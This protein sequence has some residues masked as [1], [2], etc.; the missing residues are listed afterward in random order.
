MNRIW[1]E[2]LGQGFYTPVDDMGPERVAMFEE[3]LDLLAEGFV[4]SQYDVKWVYRTIANTQAYQRKIQAVDGSE[5]VPPFA[6]AAPTRLSSDQIYQSLGQVLG[7]PSGL[8]GGGSR[9]RQSYMARRGGLDP[10]KQLFKQTFGVD[11]S[12]PKDE[13]LGNI[14]QGLFMMNSPLLEQMIRGTGDTKLARILRDQSDDQ[15]ALSEL[16]LLVLSRE[17]TEKELGINTKYVD[18]IGNRT[19]AFEDIMWS[20]LNS[21]EFLS[22]R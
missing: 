11:P 9:S 7:K 20:L 2:M 1:A 12:T 17:P 16:Y 6:S 8:Q 4:E 18:K 10:G 14:P 19:E 3:V 13:V 5:Y 22:K 21:T 15:D